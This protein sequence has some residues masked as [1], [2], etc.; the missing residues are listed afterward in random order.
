LRPWSATS[1]KIGERETAGLFINWYNSTSLEG[2]GDQ[3]DSDDQE[4]TDGRR[5]KTFPVQ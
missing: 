3:T 5:D 1:M 2:L 4:R